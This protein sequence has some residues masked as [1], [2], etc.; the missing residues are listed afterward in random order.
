MAQLPQLTQSPYLHLDAGYTQA[1]D[2]D[3]NSNAIYVGW[4]VPM[5]ANKA[6]PVW[7]IAQY[8][9]DASNR[10]TDIKWANGVETFV[11][12]WNNRASLTYQ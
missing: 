4:A 11:N 5:T 1:F 10:V 9:Y 2:Y 7:R 3:A 8:T 12:I 6:N